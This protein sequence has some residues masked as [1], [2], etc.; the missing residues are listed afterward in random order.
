[1]DAAPTTTVRE[2]PG[3][4]TIAVG[5]AFLVPL[6]TRGSYAAL[7]RTRWEWTLLFAAG[8]ALQASSGLLPGDG[9]WDLPFGALIAGYVLLLA[10]GLR[11]AIHTGMT[12]VCIGIAANFLSITVNHGMPVS[13]PQVWESR[14]GLATTVKHHARTDTDRLY[15][16][17]DVIY[18]PA[19]DEVIS[20][21]DLVIA[22]GMLDVTFHAS[23]RRRLRRASSPHPA[24]TVSAPRSRRS[25]S[26][27]SQPAA[28]ASKAARVRSSSSSRI[29]DLNV[30]ST[31]D[32]DAFVAS[33]SSTSVPAN[34]STSAAAL[35]RASR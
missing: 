6:V 8:F 11:N 29:V 12:V 13:V 7:T 20:F 3:F 18:V 9:R 17:S 10:F 16:L 1:M 2:M 15:W 35:P 31:S 5:V 30:E 19:T 34:W 4:L 33:H 24:R 23:R 21:G 28:T 27:A 25:T 32:G 26:G 14:G 22:I